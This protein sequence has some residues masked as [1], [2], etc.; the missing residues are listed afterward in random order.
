MSARKG[1]VALMEP[2]GGEGCA[3]GF[4]DW[5]PVAGTGRHDY[6]ECRRCSARRVV[7]RQPFSAP[8]ETVDLEWICRARAVPAADRCTCL[9]GNRRVPVEEVEGHDT[10]VA[11]RRA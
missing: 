5:Q 3:L 4:H 1:V 10:A 11:S 2:P 8:T 9:A 7:D 6:Q